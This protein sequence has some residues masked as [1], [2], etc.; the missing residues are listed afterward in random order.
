[1]TAAPFGLPPLEPLQ[2]Q[3]ENTAQKLKKLKQKWNN[4]ETLTGIAKKDNPKCVV[5]LPS[6]IA[7]EAVDIYNTFTW[8]EEGNK[9]RIEKILEKFE[10]F[11]NPKKN[12]IH[13][14]V[15]TVVRPLSDDIEKL[16]NQSWIWSNQRV[17]YPQLDRFW[18]TRFLSKRTTPQ[19]CKAGLGNCNQKHEVIRTHSNPTEGNKSGKDT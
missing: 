19:R 8:D 6:V 15:Q 17:G 4:Y 10:L 14:W 9:P 3:Q 7:E 11:C 5:T 12:T 1:M 2:L 13:C 16:S 18:N